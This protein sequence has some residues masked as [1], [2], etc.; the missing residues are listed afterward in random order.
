MIQLDYKKLSATEQTILDDLQ[1]KVNLK[2]PFL[3]K[4]A[5][6]QNL[7]GSKGGVTG[8]QAFEKIRAELYNLCVFVG[9]CNYCEQSEANDIEH[10]HPKS[11]FPEFSF[12]WDNYLLACKQCNSAFKLDKCYIIDPSDELFS[13][14]RKTEPPH[15]THALINPRTENPNDFMV[16]NLKTFRFMPLPDLSKKDENRVKATLEILAL[17]ERDVLIEARKSA[18]RHFYDLFERLV[19]IR[20]SSSIVELEQCLYPNEEFINRNLTIGEIQ[21]Q[22]TLS[23][24][25][26]ITKN[27]H[28]S[29]WHSIKIIASRT[30][31][32]WINLFNR[33]PEALHW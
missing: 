31:E 12:V 21:E 16:L 15:K 19:R 11:F 5:E 4:T 9:V 6:A 8:K 1:H 29:V 28:P 30:D 32:R 22:L 7:W 18:S 17:N 26:H 2:T 13:V 14:P 25:K 27:Q 20:E 33:F 23:F 10:I 24:K 3:E